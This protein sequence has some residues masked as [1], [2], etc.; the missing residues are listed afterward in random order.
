MTVLLQSC[1]YIV[2]QSDKDIFEMMPSI[3]PTSCAIRSEAA[4]RKVTIRPVECLF[5]QLFIPLPGH[6]NEKAVNADVVDLV[7]MVVKDD[8]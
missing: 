6:M 4:R 3:L 8:G 7:M 1:L 5:V 2:H